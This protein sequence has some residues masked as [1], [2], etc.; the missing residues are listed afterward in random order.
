MSETWHKEFCPACNSKNWINLGNT[1]VDS[2]KMDISYY[3]CWSCKAEICLVSGEHGDEYGKPHVRGAEPWD[4]EDRG[5][6][7]QGREMPD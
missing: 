4:E 6:R 5:D 3:D 7:T 1:E 2:S